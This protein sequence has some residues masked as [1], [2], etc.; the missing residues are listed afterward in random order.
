MYET[1]SYIP[2]EPP[3]DEAFIEHLNGWW[4]SDG[5][6]QEDERWSMG[7]VSQWLRSGIW[8]HRPTNTL[9]GGPYGF[10]WAVLLLLKA[11]WSI[12]ELQHGRKGLFTAPSRAV[13]DAEMQIVESD[14]L[15]LSDLLDSSCTTLINMRKISWPEN[16]LHTESATRFVTAKRH[17][18]P[19]FMVRVNNYSMELP[20]PTSHTGP[21]HR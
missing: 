15:W 13:L 4:L 6:F 12:N 21:Y 1:S 2:E 5:F 19:E 20:V 7:A 10:K 16:S 9:F 3:V 17:E 8:V 14:I 11:H 18:K